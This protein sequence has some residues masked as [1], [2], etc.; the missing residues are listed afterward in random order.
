VPDTGLRED[1]VERYSRNILLREV[2]GA[3]QEKLLASRVLLVGAGGLGS[4]AA[5]YLAAA[6]VGTLGVADSDVV[7]LTNLQRQIAHGTD[8]IGKEKVK[9]IASAIRRLNPDVTVLMHGRIG[10]DHSPLGDYDVVLDGSDNFETRFFV[11]DAAVRLGVPLVSAAVLRFT[12]Q[13]TTVFPG[14]GNP[15]YRCLYPGPPPAGTVP[16]CSQA[17]VLGSIAGTMGTLQATETVKVLL[18]KG[19]LL[20]GKLLLY[21]G[22]A[23]E[24]RTVRYRQDPECGTCGGGRSD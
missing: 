22:L 20:V 6:G 15:C 18:G 21:D 17:G 16:A 7:D 3:G 23:G 5:L 8:S 24:F 13:L 4:P 1:Q 12:G 2:G 14:D 10:E 19:E 11:N 9:S